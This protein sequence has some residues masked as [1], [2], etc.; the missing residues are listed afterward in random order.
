MFNRLRAVSLGTGA[1]LTLGLI[2]LTPTAEAHGAHGHGWHHHHRNSKH[3]AY[4]RGYRRGYRRALKQAYRSGYPVYRPVAYPARPVVISPYPAAPH[5][6]WL[7][8]G[9][10]FPL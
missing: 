10:A 9:A 2:S 7:S 5:H 4:D 6:S 8:I 3:K 1:L